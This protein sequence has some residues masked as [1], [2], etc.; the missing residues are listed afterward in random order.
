MNQNSSSKICDNF[1]EDNLVISLSKI[2]PTF[3][4][5]CSQRNGCSRDVQNFP[6]PPSLDES[7]IHFSI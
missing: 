7:W 1:G 5:T 2:C 4:K 6:P 3:K